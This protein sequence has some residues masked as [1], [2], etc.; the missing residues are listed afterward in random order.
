MDA[1]TKKAAIG[2]ELLFVLSLCFS[3]WYYTECEKEKKGS[4]AKGSAAPSPPPSTEEE[5]ENIHTEEEAHQAPSLNKIGFIDYEDIQEE[6]KQPFQEIEKVKKEYTRICPQCHNGF[7]HKSH[8]H[9]YCNRTCM[10]E[11]RELRTEK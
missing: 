3:W 9:T 10:L 2:F 4:K 6:Q 8:N 11:A 1:S 5:L 7:I